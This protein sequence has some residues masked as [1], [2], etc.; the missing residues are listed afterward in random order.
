LGGADADQVNILPLCEQAHGSPHACAFCCRA[1]DKWTLKPDWKQP[2]DAFLSETSL[3]TPNRGAADAG[4]ARHFQHRQSITGKKH[5]F[6]ALHVFEG[7]VAITDGLFE[8]FGFGSVQEDAD[9]LGHGCR[10]ARLRDFVNP[11]SAAM[12]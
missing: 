8:A 6:G 9:G 5:D 10:I 12:H 11:M 2:F 1:L 7:T 4:A 3:P